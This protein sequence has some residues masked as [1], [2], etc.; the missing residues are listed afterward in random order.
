MIEDHGLKRI[1]RL[2]LTASTEI[3]TIVLAVK[4]QVLDGL[5]ETLAPLLAKDT[6]ILSIMAGITVKR[7]ENLF[8]NRPVVRAMPNTPT[9]VGSGISVCVSNPAGERFEDQATK[10]LKVGG[11]VEWVRIAPESRSRVTAEHHVLFD[12]LLKQQTAKVAA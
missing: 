2:S 7:L 11:D 8:G 4:P 10:L 9:A 12:L 3:G 5:A 6:A 1:D